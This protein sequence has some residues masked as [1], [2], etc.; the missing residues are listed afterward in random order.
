MRGYLEE[1]CFL[2]TT[3]A[4]RDETRTQ[5]Y[6]SISSM[7]MFS[8]VTEEIRQMF[9]S[10]RP[11]HLLVFNYYLLTGQCSRERQKWKGSGIR[12]QYPALILELWI[13]FLPHLSF[14]RTVI[15]YSCLHFK[16]NLKYGKITFLYCTR[17]E[18]RLVLQG[19]LLVLSPVFPHQTE[20][21]IPYSHGK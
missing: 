14:N 18:F 12:S 16:T 10:L 6:S 3:H 13:L 20:L 19:H 17:G 11:S 21:S 5:V 7:C 4:P 15:V 2:F 1:K 8:W 9:L